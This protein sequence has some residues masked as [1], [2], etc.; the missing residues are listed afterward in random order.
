MSRGGIRLTR[1]HRSWI[2]ASGALL[3]LSGVAWLIAHFG[4]RS[5]GEF[6]QVESPIAPWSL[7]IHGAAAM[8]ALVVLGTLLPSHVRRA[9]HARRHRTA[10]ALLLG[11]NGLL[12]ASG[13]ALYYAGGEE[14][15]AIVSP[16]HWA[17]GLL[18]PI[19]LVWHVRTA[20]TRRP[21]RK[22]RGGASHRGTA[23]PYYTEVEPVPLPQD[24]PTLHR[25]IVENP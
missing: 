4:L 11:V 14:T 10:G 6:G 17:V 20:S 23:R 12:I 15:R 18:L 2:Y 9:W 25:T 22:R 16:L 1:R 8:L 3:F 13:Y 19:A 21:T 7:R 5:A 24:S